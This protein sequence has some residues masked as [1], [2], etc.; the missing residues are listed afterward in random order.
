MR[1]G[2]EGIL[3]PPQAAQHTTTDP[4]GTLSGAAG[5]HTSFL[6]SPTAVEQLVDAQ[7]RVVVV[8]VPHTIQ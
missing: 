1:R 7:V 5:I 3:E 2:G 4:T 8:G 6:E